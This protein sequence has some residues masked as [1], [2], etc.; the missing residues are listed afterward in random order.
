MHSNIITKLLTYSELPH[1][2]VVPL[3]NWLSGWELKSTALNA[4][5]VAA[6]KDNSPIVTC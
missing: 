4:H 5:A 3:H 2:T 1:Q 6:T